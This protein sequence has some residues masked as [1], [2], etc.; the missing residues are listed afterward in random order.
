MRLNCLLL[1]LASCTL[2]LSL[3][4]ASAAERIPVE[5]FAAPPDVAQVS[6]SPDGNRV[7]LLQRV[8]VDGL[9]G[10]AIRLIDLDLMDS[11]VLTYAKA[12]DF[13]INWIRWANSDYLLVSARFPAVRYGTPTT[14]TRMLSL[15]VANREMRSVLTKSF[16]R[17]QDRIPQYQDQIID[18]LPSDKEHILLAGRFQ[19]APGSKVIKVNITN[20]KVR[21]QTRQ[22]HNV[23]DWVTD[24]QERVRISVE[25]EDTEIRVQ[26]RA[27]DSKA[28]TT[29]WKFEQFGDD[30][31]WP[32]G[33]DKDPDILYVNAY[34]EGLKAIFKVDI[35]DPKLPMEL[36]FSHPDYDAVGRLIYSKLTGD[37]IGIRHSVGSG[38]TFWDK[39]YERLKESIDATLPD[40]KNIIYGLSDDENRYVVLAT[41]DTNPGMF[42]IGDRDEH[43]IGRLAR[44]YESLKPEML[45][46]KQR[47]SYEARDGLEIKGYLTR[48]NG[49][50]EG[51][52]LPAIIFPHGG[53]ISRTGSGFDYWTQFFASRGYVVLQMNFRGSSGH[54]FDFMASGL[55]GW[56]LEMQ[57]DVEDGTRWLIGEG[58]ADP[59]KVCVVGGSYGGY[60]ALMEAARNPELYDCAVSF[61]GVT[62]VA[63]LV[64]SYRNFTNYE[65]VKQQIGDDFGELR[66]RSPLALADEINI[67]VLLGHGTEDRR[68][69]VR[70]S[71][72][73]HRAL[74]KRGKDVSYLE[75]DGGD[76]FLSNEQHRLQFFKAMEAFL[77]ANLN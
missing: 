2:P 9:Y 48:P 34:R 77:E 74:E 26:H 16:L 63:Y 61:A 37:V 45:A 44:R 64:R 62:D 59:D 50:V 36:V 73:M 12:E 60:A 5:A 42:F 70:H 6:L 68:V 75:F 41:S 67:P 39:K 24:R 21:P 69:R 31:V 17:R 76:H 47:I 13:V 43:Q 57:N 46:E 20:G 19:S 65:V 54:G 40:T 23:E 15:N 22:H 33:F 71:Q 55:Q 25:R 7:A 56:G 10:Q 30:V 38:I 28:W 3:E 14:E 27:V 66:E 29:L 18:L 52:P 49:S 4:A 8:A 58:I 72:K 1:L 51:E 11:Q 53:P 35:A 32:L